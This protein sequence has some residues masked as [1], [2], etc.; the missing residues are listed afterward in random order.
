MKITEIKEDGYIILQIEG[1]VDTI[2]APDLQDAI[3]LGFQKMKNMELDFKNVEYVSS[4]GL[5]AL[6][7]GYKT[8]TSKGGSMILKHVS[9]TVMDVFKMTG[10]SNILEIDLKE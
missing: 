1:R 8:A 6:L 3:L 10:L 4:A 9:D 7:L 2:T 5:R